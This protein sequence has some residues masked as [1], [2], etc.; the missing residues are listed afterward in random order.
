M[1]PLASLLRR[2]WPDLDRWQAAHLERPDTTEK[3]QPNL[4]AGGFL[5]LLRRLCS[6]FLQVR[7]LLLSLN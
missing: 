3:V 2:V 4:A 6:V 1:R 7:A 5:E